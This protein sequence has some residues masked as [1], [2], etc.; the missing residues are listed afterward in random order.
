ML[1]ARIGNVGGAEVAA[2]VPVSFYD[3]DP[4]RADP[5]SAR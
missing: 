4:R 3:R 5:C 1:T 2:G